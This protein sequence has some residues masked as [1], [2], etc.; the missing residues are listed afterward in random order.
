MT[1]PMLHPQTRYSRKPMTTVVANQ[2]ATRARAIRWIWIVAMLM[3]I[4]NIALIGYMVATRRRQLSSGEWVLEIFSVILVLAA[5]TFASVGALIASRRAENRLGA[6][7]LAIGILGL[8][9]SLLASAAR[10]LPAGNPAAWCELVSRVAFA[11][12]F[13]LSITLLILLFPT[14]HLISRRWR[15][16]VL[17]AIASALVTGASVLI[18]PAFW[19]SNSHPGLS[20]PLYLGSPFNTYLM[21]QRANSISEKGSAIQL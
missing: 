17:L 15:L 10:L 14:G 19:I 11:L 4:A 5:P 12:S 3:S 8:F 20:N 2:P 7:C 1:P 13:P 6:L 16:V 9:A 18:R 21:E